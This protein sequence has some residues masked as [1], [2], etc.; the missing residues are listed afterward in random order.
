MWPGRCSPLFL[1]RIGAV[2]P[3][4]PGQLQLADC[5]Y[6][7]GA[8]P[9]T[10]THCALHTRQEQQDPI[11]HRIPSRSTV[12]MYRILDLYSVHGTVPVLYMYTVHVQYVPAYLRY[13]RT[14]LTVEAGTKTNCCTSA[15]VDSEAHRRARLSVPL[16][17]RLYWNESVYRATA[18]SSW[19]RM[20]RRAR[21]PTLPQRL[22]V[23][24]NTIERRSL[25]KSRMGSD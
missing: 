7:D 19:L 3:P 12:Y 25:L 10:G 15:S 13:E 8:Q 14:C 6:L 18:R 21:V 4:S 24:H 17:I 20:Y 22:D 11:R 5:R 1:W 9:P 23:Q 16:S 2:L